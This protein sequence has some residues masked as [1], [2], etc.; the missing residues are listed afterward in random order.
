MPRISSTSSINGAGFMKWMPM[1]RSGR[2]VEEA[3][4]VIDIEDVLAQNGLGLSTGADEDRALDVL[5]LGR[6]LDDE[7]DSAKR[8]SVSAGV[9]LEAAGAPRR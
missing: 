8:S 3:S 6:R 7:V 5:L 9:T 1:K 2:S 4:R